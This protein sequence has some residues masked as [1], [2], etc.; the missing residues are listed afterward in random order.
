MTR[1]RTLLAAAIVLAASL[2][3]GTALTAAVSLSGGFE[4]AAERAD[5]PDLIVRFRGRPRAEV[6]ERLGALPNV[7]TV[8]Y[9]TEFN[10]VLL[11]GGDGSTDKGAVHFVGPGR[12]GYAVVDGRDLRSP[13]EVVVEAGVA[14][15]WGLAVGDEVEIGRGRDLRVVGI[16]LSPDNVAF[17][18][19]RAA[20]VYV[21][22]DSFPGLRVDVAL[23]WLA[24]SSRADVTLAQ[25]RAVSF[26]LDDLRF[27][28]RDGVRVLIGQAAGIVIALLVAF[29]LV[30][31]ATAGIM[32]GASARSEVARR[33]RSIGV[34]RAVGFSRRAV[35]RDQAARGALI[36]APAAALGVAIGALAMRGAA[37]RLLAALNEIGPGA[38]LVWWLLAAWLGIVAL[39]AA[40]G[41][42]VYGVTELR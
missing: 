20:R 7:E 30:A 40:A 15:E 23:A 5:L 2:V 10:D 25:A 31:V 11:S 27:V 6:E 39:V 13:G 36:A 8:Q 38:A 41:G 4:R 1:G 37:E 18:L 22:R 14:R 12:R 34:Q 32:L 17:P 19:A 21:S 28:T 3:C 29:S 9:R 24:D 26:G 33:L 42:G 16:G 35:V